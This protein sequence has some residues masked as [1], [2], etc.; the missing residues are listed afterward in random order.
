MQIVRSFQDPIQKDQA[1]L[2]YGLLGY[3]SVQSATQIRLG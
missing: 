2:E 1:R 3:D